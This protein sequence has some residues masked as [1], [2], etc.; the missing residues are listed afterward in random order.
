MESKSFFSEVTPI[1]ARWRN[2]NPPSPP[3]PDWFVKS[4]KDIGG[5]NPQG[6]PILRCI[7]PGSHFHVF[8]GKVRI[9]YPKVRS[10][11]LVG[12]EYIDPTDE[13]GERR[14]IAP[15]LADVPPGC[16]F[17]EVRDWTDEAV[18]YFI[19]E[20]WLEPSV[21]GWNPSRHAWV[22]GQKV[23]KLGDMPEEG[24]YDYLWTMQ[25]DEGEFIP[26]GDFALEKLR[27][28]RWIRDND[29]IL[30]TFSR[31]EYPPPDVIEGLVREAE[32]EAS[33]ADEKTIEQNALDIEE[34]LM[35]HINEFY[36][37]LNESNK[38]LYRKM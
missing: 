24:Y 1:A 38:R 25:T 33:L 8:E 4:L 5:I 11:I 9:K 7:W 28:F 6:K 31:D 13:A 32:Y 37:A 34:D 14:I 10:K 20:E 15:Q 29:P 35:G 12:F 21:V 3:I 26:P 17:T 19:I 16:P 30:K 23:D 2:P 27:K 22:N 18:P 36:A